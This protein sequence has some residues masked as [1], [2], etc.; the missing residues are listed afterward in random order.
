M[1][2]SIT[3]SVKKKLG[4][5][6]WMGEGTGGAVVPLRPKTLGW[7]WQRWW[8]RWWPQW[9]QRWW[10]RWWQQWWN[11]VA[12]V[13]ENE[14]LHKINCKGWDKTR[15]CCASVANPIHPAQQSLQCSI[16][17]KTNMHMTAQYPAHCHLTTS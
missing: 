6:W 8:Q 14:K 7:Q 12:T 16:Q 5:R 9:W 3:S 13:A 11:A 17:T 10:Q 15:I 1:I 2:S 4:Q